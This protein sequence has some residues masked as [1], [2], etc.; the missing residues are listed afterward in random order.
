MR[1]KPKSV[2]KV[3]DQ[4]IDYPLFKQV[5]VTHRRGR[6]QIRKQVYLWSKCCG[7]EITTNRQLAEYALSYDYFDLNLNEV[8]YLTRNVLEQ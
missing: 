8:S 6:V 3:V 5:F 2:S 4:I 1:R 7:L